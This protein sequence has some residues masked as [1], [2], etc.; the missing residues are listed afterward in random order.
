ML[1]RIEVL[2]MPKRNSLKT[3]FCNSDTCIPVTVFSAP[4]HTNSP[5]CCRSNWFGSIKDTLALSI[6]HDD[7]VFNFR[8]T[9][10]NGNVY[11]ISSTYEN[12]INEF[13]NLFACTQPI[14]LRIDLLEDSDRSWVI[15]LKEDL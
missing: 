4:T 8:I 14:S 11:D 2:Y 1:K 5:S 13:R 10:I 3:L 12:F 7:Q 9:C 6:R 15:L